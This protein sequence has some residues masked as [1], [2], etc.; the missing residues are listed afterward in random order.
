MVVVFVVAIHPAGLDLVVELRLAA[1]DESGRVRAEGKVCQRH[2]AGALVC[3]HVIIGVGL[4]EHFHL[5]TGG[6]RA[7]Y[8]VARQ[9]IVNHYA[10]VARFVR[11]GK[12][13]DGKRRAGIFRGQAD[14]R[15]IAHGARIFL[16]FAY[17]DIRP[18]FVRVVKEVRGIT[19]HGGQRR[20]DRHLHA[21]KEQ[22]AGRLIVVRAGAHVGRAGN[23]AGDPC[24]PCLRRGGGGNGV[25]FFK[26]GAVKV[27][28]NAQDVA[29][30]DGKI[31][32]QRIHRA[33]A[34]AG[35]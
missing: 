7:R 18:H 6:E 31:D 22:L 27:V 35:R 25:R 24:R 30:L 17:A 21:V 15:H 2:K 11:R 23:R 14:E 20:Q 16:C 10:D 26:Y 12:R 9:P 13:G 34:R 29:V 33:I 8:G 32:K 19:A 28:R 5:R 1:F 4:A 3:A